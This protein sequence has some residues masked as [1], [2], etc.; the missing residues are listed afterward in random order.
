[1]MLVSAFFTAEF[2]VRPPVLYLIPTF[3]TDRNLSDDVLV[4]H[5]YDV[6]TFHKFGATGKSFQHLRT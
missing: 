2:L 5:R 4:F 6:E 1:M 3:E